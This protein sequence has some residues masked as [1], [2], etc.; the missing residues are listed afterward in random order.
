GAVELPGTREQAVELLEAFV[1]LMPDAAVVV[2]ET[3]VIVSANDHAETLFGYGPGELQGREVEALVPERY[4]HRHR[5]HRADYAA[6]A[7]ARPM[8]AGLEL[9]GRRLDGSEFPVD[10]SLAPLA[11]MDRPL[12]VAAIRDA[13]ERTAATAALA[14]LAA[15]VQSSSDAI[16]SVTLEGEITSWNPGAQR[17]FGYAESEIVGRHISV[18]VPDERSR[19]FEEL[20]D[21]LLAGETAQRDTQWSRRDGRTIDVALA[22]SPLTNPAG[23]SLGFS[24]MVRDITER[25][26]A[27]AELRRRER[28]QTVTAEIR[29]ALLS[30]TSMA[31]V[32]EMICRRSCELLKADAAAIAIYEEGQLRVAAAVGRA[33]HVLGNVLSPEA[34]VAGRVAA[35]GEAQLVPS[36]AD[37]PGIDAALVAS[38]PSGPALGVPVASGQGI[39]GALV[40]TREAGHREFDPGQAALA[41]SLA[42]Q[43]ALGLELGRSRD[44]R[45]R[46]MLVDDR[47]RIAR[48]LHDLV[49]QRL[50]AAGMRLQGVVRL[51]HD[52]EVGDR[53][54]SVV[55]ELDETIREIRATIFAL[56]ASITPALG[57]RG[58][59]L[60]LAEEVAEGLGFQ[61]TFRFDGPVDAMVPDDVVPHLLAVV[62]ETLSNAARH[63]RA[64]AVQVDLRVGTDVVVV[65]QDDGVGLGDTTRQSGLANLRRRAENLGGTF[66]AASPP[67]GGTRVEWR[68]PLSR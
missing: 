26:Q 34:S 43:A 35:S 7:H 2:D 67:G 21:A 28:Q 58:E 52:V 32:L 16:V 15:I 12:V 62:R 56:E 13:S 57:L 55:E 59:V 54:A 65:V 20:L 19:E 29:L 46:L 42:D 23:R 14:Q 44:D 68:V 47:E 8:G 6:S 4:R 18:L 66:R 45:E 31:E 50:F 64:T 39:S 24:A 10:I 22:L 61:P 17:L 37:E 33:R 60:R 41:R 11:G 9:T 51:S 63:A 48:D 36:L 49:I 30:G 1:A 25:K 53:V 3:G 38:I 5:R 40:L 27:E